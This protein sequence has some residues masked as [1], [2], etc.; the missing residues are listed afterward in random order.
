MAIPGGIS[1]L[2]LNTTALV[3][4]VLLGAMAET[5]SR[6]WGPDW[7]HTATTNNIQADDQS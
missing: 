6:K 1:V 4:A 3:L 7:L 5:G 2:E